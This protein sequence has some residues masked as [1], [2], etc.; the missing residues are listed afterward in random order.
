MFHK[1]GQRI[2]IITFF[3]VVAAVL[4]AHYYVNLEWARFSLQVAALIFLI[5][6]LQFFRNPKRDCFFGNVVDFF[7][8]ILEN[9]PEWYMR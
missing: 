2:I 7:F 6:I 8:C 3:I 1:E 4:A 5:A 9:F